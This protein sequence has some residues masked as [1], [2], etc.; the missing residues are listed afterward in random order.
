MKKISNKKFF[1]KKHNG[2]AECSKK[3]CRYNIQWK[4]RQ[5]TVIKPEEEIN[6][7]LKKVTENTNIAICQKIHWHTLS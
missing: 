5:E 2:T 4:S 3:Q 7:L 1:K 6:G